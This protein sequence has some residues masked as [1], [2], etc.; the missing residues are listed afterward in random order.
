MGSACTRKPKV[1]VNTRRHH[2][3]PGISKFSNWRN[4]YEPIS[5]LGNGNFGKVR[6]VRDK[7]LR[8]LKFAIKTITKDDLP[9]DYFSLILNEVDNL[10]KLDHPNVVKYYETYEDE[11]YIHFVMEYL[12]GD[13]LFQL[14]SSEK[15]D[16]FTEKD[17]AEII[18]CILMA[19]SYIHKEGVIHRDIKPENLIF[20]KKGKNDSLK[21]IDFG[22]SEK[23]STKSRKKVGSPHYMSPE[24]LD[25]NFSF[26][27]DVWSVGVIL[28]VML[29][30]CFPFNGKTNAEIFEEIK[31][32]THNFK[33]L[34]DSSCSRLAKEFVTKLLNKNV[35]QRLSLEEALNHPWI[36]FFMNLD[37]ND[38]NANK[39]NDGIIRN[40][41]NFSRK[42]LLQKEILY[43][44]AKLSNDNEITRLKT[45]FMEMDK[46]HTGTLEYQEIEKAFKNL[47]IEILEVIDLFKQ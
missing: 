38:K 1:K 27:S 39:V 36:K 45:L 44:I 12:Q 20:S 43:Y 11:K 22:L 10:A 5:L 16:N 32:K 33:Q 15:S 37:K 14:I 28:Y 42:N 4:K 21:I 35:Q 25:G 6:L 40:L 23:I 41:K 18:N 26:K 8:D 31:L 13:D 9:L 29:T 7:S 46:D 3:L 19:L 34:N 17:M 24:T 47:G 30:G 2:S